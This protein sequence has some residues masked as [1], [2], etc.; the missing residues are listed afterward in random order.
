[1]HIKLYYFVYFSMNFLWNSDRSVSFTNLLSFFWSSTPF[2]QFLKT[3][4]SSHL[5]EKKRNNLTIPVSRA[6]NIMW[7]TKLPHAQHA[8][9]LMLQLYPKEQVIFKRQLACFFNRK[10]NPYFRI[11]TTFLLF[12]QYKKLW[13]KKA[14]VA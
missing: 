1:M 10:T 5:K 9:H 4:S 12:F 6:K 13:V 11:H 8:H 3:T 2:A 14:E 7:T